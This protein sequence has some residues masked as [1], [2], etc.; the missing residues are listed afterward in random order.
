MPSWGFTYLPTEIFHRASQTR[1]PRRSICFR[2]KNDFT[3]GSC[4]KLL[5]QLGFAPLGRTMVPPSVIWLP[6]NIL[7]RFSWSGMG[8][9]NLVAVF[10]WRHALGN[11]KAMGISQIWTSQQNECFTLRIHY[12]YSTSLYNTNILRIFTTI[13]ATTLTMEGPDHVPEDP[14]FST[15]AEGWPLR[16]CHCVI[17]IDLHLPN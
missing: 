8:A 13:L 7:S 14:K 3:G 11:E 6:Y 2:L 1:A 10:C 16:K 5:V 9:A 15:R 17:P 4:F 12:T